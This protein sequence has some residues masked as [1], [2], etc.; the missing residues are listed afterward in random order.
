MVDVQSK[1]DE[2]HAIEYSAAQVT[3]QNE[4][5]KDGP[6]LSGEARTEDSVQLKRSSNATIVDVREL[7]VGYVAIGSTPGITGPRRAGA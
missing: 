4:F 6:N 3:S 5:E 7:T 1:Q 2:R